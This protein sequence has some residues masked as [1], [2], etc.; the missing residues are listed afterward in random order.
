NEVSQTIPDVG[1]A[2]S[3]IAFGDGSLW[4]ADTIG[5][6]LVEVDPASGDTKGVPLTGQ[7]SGVTFTATGVWVSV[8][9]AGVARVDPADLSVTLAYQGVGNGPTAVLPAFGSIWA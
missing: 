5:S 3:A 8:A 4:V 6:E 1:T 9:P 7:P 2:P